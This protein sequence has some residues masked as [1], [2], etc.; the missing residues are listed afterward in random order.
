MIIIDDGAERE[1]LTLLKHERESLASYK[2]V[3]L[4]PPAATDHNAAFE[5]ICSIL[6]DRTHADRQLLFRCTDHDIFFLTPVLTLKDFKLISQKILDLFP[7]SQHSTVKLQIIEVGIESG[8]IVEA[9]QK[10]LDQLA[11]KNAAL[12]DKRKQLS[13]QKMAD[14]LM[15]HPITPNQLQRIH[16][17]RAERTK[18]HI[19]V[20]EDDVFLQRLIR[21]VLEPLGSVTIVDDSWAALSAYLTD[22]PDLIF[23]DINLP[24]VS[25]QQLLRK[26]IAADSDA[27]I[28]MLTGNAD[29]NNVMQA[30]QH[31]AKG[32]V[33]KPF[34]REKLVHYAEQAVKNRK[35]VTA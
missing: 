24:D 30:M 1:L 20:V 28:V 19:L 22:A 33:A 13:V 7:A 32:F 29:K 21:N 18:P 12:E 26:L 4:T 27:F 3:T 16:A 25:G 15:N 5:K 17:L 9:L 10:K 23:L 34:T 14:D 6:D 31:G 8:L 35:L 11:Q 2:I